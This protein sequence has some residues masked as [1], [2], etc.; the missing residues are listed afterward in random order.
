[1]DIPSGGEEIQDLQQIQPSR[2]PDEGLLNTEATTNNMLIWED[3]ISGGRDSITLNMYVKTKTINW[4]KDMDGSQSGTVADIDQAWKDAYN[5]DE[6]RID[7]DGDGVLDTEDDLDGDGQWDYRIEPSNPTISG[8][9]SQVTSGKTNVYDKVL[10][11]YEYLISDESLTYETIRG[12][13]L[14][15]A[16]TTTLAEKKG[17]CDDYSILFVS[18]CRAADIPARL[19]LGLL[20]DPGGDQWIGHGW[21]GVYIPLKSGGAFIGTVDIVN[22]Q[23]LFRDPYRITDWYDTGGDVIDDG[24]AVSNLDFYYYSFSYV[25]SGTKESEE[26]TT[27]SYKPYGRV[28]IEMSEAEI[29][30]QPSDESDSGGRFGPLPGFEAAGTLAAI[31]ITAAVLMKFRRT[32]I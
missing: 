16:C 18:L 2:A 32:K 27:I 20:Y 14:P 8:I 24:K 30:G 6:W 11:I 15:K 10:A 12:S 19:H 28:M 23:F 4:G 13:G 25:G 1:M 22:K 29:T 26:Y 31:G 5:H 21:S 7:N 3:T 17:D 9:A